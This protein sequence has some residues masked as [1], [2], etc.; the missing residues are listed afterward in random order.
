MRISYHLWDVEFREYTSEAEMETRLR[1][2]APPFEV[3]DA[4]GGYARQFYSLEFRPQVEGTETTHS[5]VGF[6]SSKTGIEPQV[7]LIPA[8]NLVCVGIDSSLYMLDMKRQRTK[9]VDLGAPFYWMAHLTSQ[10]SI[11]VV[12]EIG[13]LLLSSCGETVWERTV[14]GIISSVRLPSHSSLEIALSGGDTFTVNLK[15]GDRRDVP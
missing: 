6:C 7:L 5:S 11:L 3:H 10:D 8:V 1:R 15:P 14:D 9:R 13:V 2:S 4:S 12:H